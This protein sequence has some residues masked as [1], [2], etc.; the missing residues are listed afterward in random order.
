MSANDGI[1]KVET[2]EP[3][4]PP[5]DGFTRR[6]AVRAGTLLGGGALLAQGIRKGL[7]VDHAADARSLTEARE[8]E[9]AKPENI[10]YTTCLQC[11]TGCGVKAKILDGVVVKID[12]SPYSPWAMYPHL[13]YKTAPAD[14]AKI[15]GHL[16]PKGAAGIQTAYDPYR[17][18]RVL[19]R[20][21]KRGEKK[22]VSI[23]FDQAVKEIV[24]GGTLFSS[25]P[26]EEKRQVDGFKSVWA[27]RDKAVLKAFA[28]D[29]AKI[30]HGEMT[31]AEF[32]TKNAAHLDKLI[33][34]DHPDLG[35]KNNQFTFMFGRLKGGRSEFIKRFVLESFGSTNLHG[36]T[37]VCQGSL[38]FTGKAMS[39]QYD[40][41]EKDKKVKWTGGD[42]FYWQGDVANAEFVLFV[43]SAVWEGG[44]G[45]P[46]RSARLTENLSKGTTKI[47]VVDPR[48]SKLAS[49]A[50]RWLPAKSGSEGAL[51]LGM[52]R[53]ILEKKR[54]NETF[55]ANAN[56]GA[57]A[58]DK[59][60]V[61]TNAV[62]AV[63]CDGKPKVDKEGK[64]V[65]G[66][67]G[68]PALEFKPG[69]F[70]YGSEIGLPKRKKTLTKVVEKVALNPD[71]TA[72]LDD[73]GK[74]KTEKVAEEV[75]GED[76]KPIVYEMDL[77][78]VFKAGKLTPFDPNDEKEVAEGDLFGTTKLTVKDKDGKPVEIVAMTALQLLKESAEA[79]TIEQWA[80]I[81][82]I[83]P[84]AI[85]ELAYE[86]T[87][88]GTK[89]VADIHRGVSQHTNG[90][91]NVLAWYS[92][93]LLIGSF[94]HKGGI[95]K[96]SAWAFDGSKPGQP[97]N[98]GKMNPGKLGEF[99]IS[100]I[101][102]NVKYEETTLFDKEKGKG[103]YPA[104]RQ[105]W[106]ISSDVYQEII[107]SIGDQYPYPTK[108]LITYMASPAY[109]LAGGQTNAAILSDTAKVPL[110]IASDIMV[111][112]TSM[113]ADYIFPDLSYLERWEFH[114]TH[115]TSAHKVQPVRQPVIAPIP[116]TAKVFG[117]ETP[118]AMES[119]LMAIAEKLGMKGWGKNGFGEGKD[120]EHP[121][122]FYL[123]C[124][125][126][127]ASGEKPVLEQGDKK[128]WLGGVP[129]ADD[130]EIE[131]FLK[132]RR[133]LPKTVFDEA[134]WKKAAGQA[135]WK[136]VIYVL[137]RGGR[138]DDFD[139]GYEGAMVKNRYAKQANMYCEKTAKCKNAITGKSNHGIAT[140]VPISG[141]DGKPIGDEAKGFD[142]HMI[143]YKA[144][145]HTKSR[146]IT[147]YYLNALA[148][149]NAFLM[150]P[151]DA[152]SRGMEDGARV[153]VV[154]ATNPDGVMDLQA[155]GKKD[156]IGKIKVTE[157]IR[158]GVIAFSLGN[159]HW[160]NGSTDI[161]LDGKVVPGD[162]R[163]GGGIHANSAMRL[164][165]TLK[166][167]CL[168]DP[169]GGSVS[170]YDSKVKLVKV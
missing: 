168:L 161:V 46:L 131:L 24:E 154:S 37:T 157:G 99:G 19:K 105:W 39:E 138:I 108:V 149:D 78:L 104:K 96:G 162:P 98:F 65:L 50:W 17:I 93:N 164:D 129:D 42:K 14:M 140:Y 29:V 61:W 82:G 43:G 160:A 6:D 146:T 64:E 116:E 153:R 56:K 150:N 170:F 143:T 132:S 141:I 91:Y 85:V 110:Y 38:Y 84:Q 15:D 11:N 145:H 40:F 126:N 127:I 107:P 30:K 32:K 49:K 103:N 21:G 23:P 92:L 134:R 22:W 119:L 152:K 28:E 35:P 118:I 62:W 63:K 167:T 139:K 102:H 36:H 60:T 83:E 144:V 12:G 120:F 130:K 9:L 31:V 74:P 89:A 81:C 113:F 41:D 124:V 151:V 66:D 86:M 137:N 52:I 142:L 47:A 135:M 147:N 100:V 87:N 1:E 33:D 25:V 166:N 114:G 75:K 155:G 94:D 122:D 58:A 68:K 7:A 54:Y 123:R 156:L 34:P 70:L 67:D 95:M 27:L 59:E 88:H 2:N 109:S 20:A 97:Y 4:Q 44:Y 48:F 136:K 8:Y 18:R 10:L 148:P 158:P 106:P 165:D 79:K 125:A 45:P 16:C 117:Q 13:P 72:A 128:T 90:Y 26:G 159:G 73:H 77:P 5:A 111:G 53:W 169:V 80:E 115:P 101:R 112:E 51:A 133:H 3:V 71:G 163:R 76:G 55:L 121:D 57:A 69:A